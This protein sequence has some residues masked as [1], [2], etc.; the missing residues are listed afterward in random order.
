[1]I[2]VSTTD[3]L[4]LSRVESCYCDSLIACEQAANQTDGGLRNGAGTKVDN[5]GFRRQ[6]DPD[7]VRRT[8]LIR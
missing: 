7:T 3:A 6:E 1:M 2:L 8:K 4:M 5:Q